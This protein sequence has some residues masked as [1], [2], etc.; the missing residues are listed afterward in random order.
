MFVLEKASAEDLSRVIS[1]PSPSPKEGAITDRLP[2]V[3]LTG[4]KFTVTFTATGPLASR[5]PL[6]KVTEESKTLTSAGKSAWLDAVPSTVRLLLVE[7]K[8][9][10]MRMPK[11]LTGVANWAESR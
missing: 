2:I 6:E 7:A 9:L 5:Y 10:K 11:T 3:W 4:E 1:F 8:R